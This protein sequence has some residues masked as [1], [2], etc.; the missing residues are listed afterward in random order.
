VPVHQSQCA[1]A[2]Y[3]FFGFFLLLAFFFV[4]IRLMQSQ[5]I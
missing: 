4:A 5:T 2:H 1:I 3:F